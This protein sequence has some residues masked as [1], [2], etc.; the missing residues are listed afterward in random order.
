MY[1]LFK[2]LYV[3]QQSFAKAPYMFFMTPTVHMNINVRIRKHKR[4]CLAP[5]YAIIYIQ[6]Q[7]T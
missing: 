1:V 6:I 2:L 4:D 5:V 3:Y 7:F